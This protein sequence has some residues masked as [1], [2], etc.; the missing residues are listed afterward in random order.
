MTLQE[1][2]SLGG[3]AT[4][5]KRAGTNFYRDMAAKSLKARGLKPKKKTV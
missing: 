2:R 4:A 5:K 1:L 3:K